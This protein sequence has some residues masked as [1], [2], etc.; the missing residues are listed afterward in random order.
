[1][2]SHP[3][4]PHHPSHPRPTRILRPPQT[5]DAAQIVSIATSNPTSLTSA[6]ANRPN[7]QGRTCISCGLE[8]ALELIEASRRTST[9]PIILL[10]TDGTQTVGG[11]NQKAIDVGERRYY[12][13]QP[14]DRSA[15]KPLWM[16]VD[17]VC[18]A[19]LKLCSS[20]P[21]SPLALRN[22]ATNIKAQ[23]IRILSVGFGNIDAVTM[24]ALASTPD[25]TYAFVRCPLSPTAL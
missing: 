18:V 24:R 22:A 14:G 21:S 8:K 16:C 19:V 1:M 13:Y 2:L 12:T 4:S 15:R 20:C 3:I 7:S 10:L 25:E 6:I 9:L 23:G 11:T 17:A 5:D